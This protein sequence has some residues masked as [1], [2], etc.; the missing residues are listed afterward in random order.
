MDDY[1][2]CHMY[3]DDNDAEEIIKPA[4][5][6]FEIEDYTAATDWE[7]F[8]DQLENVLRGW[9][10]SSAGNPRYEFHCILY[11]NIVIGYFQLLLPVL[12]YQLFFD[13]LFHIFF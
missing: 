8:T 12:W 6:V 5:D 7:D 2:G 9:K 13:S 3:S 11:F 10:L 1:V 4:V